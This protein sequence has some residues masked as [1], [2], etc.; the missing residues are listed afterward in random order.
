MRHALA[1][2]TLAL[3]VTPAMAE[4]RI[5]TI[6]PDA[7][8]LA[9]YGEHVVGVKTFEISNPD[10]IDIVNTT[11]EN[12]PRY[13]RPLTVEVWYPAAEGTQ[14]GGTYEGVNLRAASIQVALEG[15]AVRD[16]APTMQGKFPLIVISHGYPGNR[17]L[18]AHLGENLAS[19]GYVT[20]SID[21]TDSTYADQNAFGSTLLNRP[22]DQDF[23]V[24]TFADFS[25]TSPELAAI[26]DGDTVG[27]IGYSMGGYGALIYGGAGVTQ[28]S[29]EYPWGTPNGL[30]QRHLAGSGSHADMPNDK[31][32]AIISIAPWGKNTG[33]WDADGLAGFEKPLMLM[34]GSVDDVSVYAALRAIF[35]ETTGTKRHLLTFENANHNAGA[36]MPSPAEGYQMVEGLDF[37]P[38]EHYADAVW[39]N[40]RMNNI[41]QHFAT[42]FMDLHLKGDEG[43]A[44]YLDLV[45]NAADGVHKLG[46][47]GKP[48]PE[49]TYWEGFPARTAAGL[50]FETLE[51]GN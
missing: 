7:P 44:A 35:E 11:A 17:F 6:R 41:A 25:A 26:I 5:D 38:F 9:A 2:A 12:A 8:M 33:F 13:D 19:K 32:K 34:A 18:M 31:V 20:V 24:E 45:V 46:D 40:V 10:Q 30:L 43:K 23:V 1:S 49:H 4:N 42:A 47:D 14:S 39:D 29:T 48:A 27:V 37:A 3:M 50:K 16:A 22:L 36:P 28:A 15:Q 21:H 51:Q